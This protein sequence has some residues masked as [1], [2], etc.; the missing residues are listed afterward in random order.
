MSRPSSGTTR[1]PRGGS[2][3]GVAG[4]HLEIGTGVRQLRPRDVSTW[5]AQRRGVTGRPGTGVG[6]PVGAAP[7]GCGGDGSPGREARFAKGRRLE[8]P[9]HPR[10]VH[11]CCP[12][13]VSGCLQRQV[14]SVTVTGHRVA[15]PGTWGGDRIPPGDSEAVSYR[16]LAGLLGTAG[17]KP[18]EAK[19]GRLAGKP[20]CCARSHACAHWHRCVHSP[21]W[22]LR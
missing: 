14:G 12:A 6:A 20:S 15:L 11:T 16:L 13:C 4:T 1:Q 10:N 5:R 19:T 18:L 22:P 9:K 21:C 8:P 2:R 17:V 7:Q 3:T